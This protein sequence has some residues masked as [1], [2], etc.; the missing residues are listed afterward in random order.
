MKA[1]YKL[2][3]ANRC[4]RKSKCAMSAINVRKQCCY[5]ILRPTSL[6]LQ[7]FLLFNTM[8]KTNHTYIVQ[9]PLAHAL[10]IFRKP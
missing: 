4:D 5:T 9:G 8:A 10:I 6:A 2:N 1:L 7:M 3:Y